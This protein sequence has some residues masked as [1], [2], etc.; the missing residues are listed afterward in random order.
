M[1]TLLSGTKCYMTFFQG[2]FI[3]AYALAIFHLNLFI[4]FLSPKI[5]PSFE[6]AE[7]L[8]QYIILFKDCRWVISFSQFFCIL[9][10]SA[11]INCSSSNYSVKSLNDV[12]LTEDE[13]GPSLPTNTT[14]EFRPFIR[15]LPEFKF[16]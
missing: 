11:I 1:S 2:W 8:G 15:R 10:S 3:S 13:E 14:E 6:M 9:S 7:S 4:A 16:W 5:D 12:S